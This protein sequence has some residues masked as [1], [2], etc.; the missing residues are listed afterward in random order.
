LQGTA[1]V[2]DEVAE[3]TGVEAAN[4][5]KFVVTPISVDEVADV[6]GCPALLGAVRLKR[7]EQVPYRGYR[8]GV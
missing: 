6:M 1:R 5:E 3:G 4:P 7:V 8:G 2:C